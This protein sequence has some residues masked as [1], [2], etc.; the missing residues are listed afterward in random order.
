[1]SFTHYRE[2]GPGPELRQFKQFQFSVHTGFQP[3]HSRRFAL[4]AFSGAANGTN[5]KRIRRR[6]IAESS[7]AGSKTTAYPILRLETPLDAACGC[8]ATAGLIHPALEDPPNPDEPNYLYF[9]IAD[10]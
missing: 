4:P 7:E 2:L 6:F 3:T 10:R 8:G 9:E 1:L 5:K